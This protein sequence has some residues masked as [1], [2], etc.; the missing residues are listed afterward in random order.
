MT[1]DQPGTIVMLNGVMSAGKT[2][3]ARA[4]QQTFDE[5]YLHTG[6]DHFWLHMFPWDWP[7]AKEELRWRDISLAGINP[8]QTAVVNTPYA[9]RLHVGIF[10]STAALARHGLHVVI[11]YILHDRALLPELVRAWAGLQVWLIGVHCPLPLLH[12]RAAVREDR[13]GWEEYSNVITWQHQNLHT[14]VPGYDLDV[15]TSTLDPTS[16]ALRIKE[17][18]RAGD[19]KAFAQLSARYAEPDAAPQPAQG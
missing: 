10:D 14:R 17:R 9:H 7:R 5:P 18:V 15:D 12:E 16:C 13:R 19:P 3:I 11:D 2:S 6:V 1:A 8:P 4:I